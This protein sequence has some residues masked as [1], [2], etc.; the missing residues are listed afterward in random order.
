MGKDWKYV[1]YLSVIVGTFM[2]VKLLGPKQHDWRITLSHKDKSPYGMF[3]LQELL[4]SI[5]KNKKIEN[6]NFTLYEQLDS[7]SAT[8]NIII[9]ATTFNGGDEDV[10][11]LLNHLDKGNSVLISAH[12]FRG[13]LAD[14]FHLSTQ[15]FLFQSS[16]EKSLADSVALHFVNPH[17]DTTQRFYYSQNNAH[18]YF[19]RFDSAKFEV[20]ARNEFDHPVTVKTNWGKGKLILNTTPL[21]FTNIN[22]LPN[23]NHKF[24]SATLSYLPQQD[25][26]W[27]EFYHLGRMEAQSPLRF[28]L[29]N[30]PLSWSYYIALITL[31]L[32]IFFEAKR[33]QRVIPVITPLANTTLEFVATVGNLYYH[34]GDHKNLAEKKISFFH[35]QLRARL[36]LEHA[37]HGSSM[38]SIARKTG[39]DELTT[40]ALF[41]RIG[42]IQQQ[43]LI[44]STDLITLNKE[45][46][47]FLTP[48]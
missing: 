41:R 15:D 47:V 27:T 16:Q 8:E 31:L 46:E 12:F 29:T 35:D 44:T 19:N 5:F 4:P 25:V 38:E 45:I 23:R 28:V 3:V 36:G 24:A 13:I 2:A 30:E 20:I 10:E 48:K 33:K 7:V 6:A 37:L 42:Y 9:F 21:A 22:L 43:K 32:F 39:N 11:V 1:L 40:A 34:R 14:T 26:L 17:F 18:N